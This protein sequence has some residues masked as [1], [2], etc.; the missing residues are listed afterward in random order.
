LAAP[1]ILAYLIETASSPTILTSL[2]KARGNRCK[3]A[4]KM[5]PGTRDFGEIRYSNSIGADTG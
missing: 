3:A 2:G 5:N 1:A 4:K